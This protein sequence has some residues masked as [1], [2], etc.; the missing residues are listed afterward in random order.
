MP[1]ITIRAECMIKSNMAVAFCS[2]VTDLLMLQ[3]IE[4]TCLQWKQRHKLHCNWDSGFSGGIV[5]ILLI[6]M[7]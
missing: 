4:S 1:A 7:Q 2:G 3:F 6:V 5:D